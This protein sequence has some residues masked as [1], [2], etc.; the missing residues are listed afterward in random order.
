MKENILAR[1]FATNVP[2]E[3]W[4]T[5][6]TEF[7]IPVDNRKLYLSP[8]MYFCDNSIIEYELSFKNDNQFVLK[9]FD[10]ATKKYHEAKPIFPSDR[11]FQYTSNIFKNKIEEAGI[12]QSMSRVGKYIDNEPMKGS[13]GT[14]KAEIFYG[15]TFKTLEELKDKIIE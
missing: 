9:M 2:N 13:F 3:K 12:T 8:I 5:D 14:L 4:L 1:D 7:S 11:G 10:K 6:V 15:K